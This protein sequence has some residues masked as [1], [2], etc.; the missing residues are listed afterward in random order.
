MRI[1][2]GERS[3][4]AHTVEVPIGKPVMQG[5]VYSNIPGI[6]ANRGGECAC[7]SCHVHIDRG[8]ADDYRR[9]R[10]RAWVAG[11]KN[12]DVAA[13][14][15]SDTSGLTSRSSRLHGQGCPGHPRLCFYKENR[16]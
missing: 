15:Q 3:G 16:G 9:A 2:Y 1:A 10:A 14:T 12:A 7:A 5:A 6:D 11:G 4:T 8:L 13:V